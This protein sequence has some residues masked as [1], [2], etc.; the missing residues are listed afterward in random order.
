MQ[1]DLADHSTDI[2][3]DPCPRCNIHT[4]AYVRRTDREE[5]LYGCERTV[6]ECDRCEREMVAMP[7]GWY[8]L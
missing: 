2:H 4:N 7:Y 6:Y 5:Y 8:V 1:I 3:P